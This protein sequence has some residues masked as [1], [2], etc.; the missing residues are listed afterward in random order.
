[1]N[2]TLT[3]HIQVSIKYAYTRGN[4]AYWQRQIP[5][6]LRHR[7]PSSGPLKV[8][9]HTLDPVVIAS[10]VATL[11]RRHEAFWKAMR[12]DPSLSPVSAREEARKLLKSFGIE[13]AGRNTDEATLDGLLPV[14]WTLC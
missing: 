6:D 1:M 10:K 13:D 14:S 3:K 5:T 2:Y 12:K 8:N 9:L 4:T 11:N 7:Y